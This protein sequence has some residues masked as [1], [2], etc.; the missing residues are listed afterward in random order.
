MNE[1]GHT[2]RK[3]TGSTAHRTTIIIERPAPGTGDL[4]RQLDLSALHRLLGSLSGHGPEIVGVEI[5][6]APEFKP[7]LPEGFETREVPR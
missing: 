5:E 3:P 2:R 7:D 1:N 6:I 4:A